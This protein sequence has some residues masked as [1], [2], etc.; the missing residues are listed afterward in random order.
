MKFLPVARLPLLALAAAFSVHAAPAPKVAQDVDH[1]LGYIAR[2]GCSFY[3]NGTWAD[4]TIAEAHVRTKFDY[5]ARQDEIASV[6]DFIEKAASKSS[7]TGMA[8]QVKCP[9]A[10]PVLARD[11]LG[12]ELARY[13]ARR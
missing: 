2:S 7:I 13:Q 9:G 5:L 1:L 12:E 10:S 6:T 3:R 11:W 4:A 8:Y